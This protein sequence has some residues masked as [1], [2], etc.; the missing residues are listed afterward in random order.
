[1]KL[2][3]VVSNAGLAIY[4]EIAMVLF[5]AAFVGIVIYLFWPSR[6]DRIERHRS[7]PLSD[8]EP[9]PTDEEPRR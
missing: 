3:D 9:R 2:S 1:V 7:M 5:I 6:R 8:G 4:A